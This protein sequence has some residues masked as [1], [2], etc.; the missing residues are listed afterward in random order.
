MSSL[1]CHG[2]AHALG[3]ITELHLVGAGQRQGLQAGEP[4]G[5]TILP[6]EQI[7]KCKTNKQTLKCI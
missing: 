4:Q 1:Q 6:R 5:G 7:N 3:R 2:G